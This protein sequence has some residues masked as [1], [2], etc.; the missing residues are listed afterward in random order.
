MSWGKDIV[1]NMGKIENKLNE[2]IKFLQYTYIENNS[3]KLIKLPKTLY[4]NWDK[5]LIKFF[6]MEFSLGIHKAVLH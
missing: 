5:I 6:F 3:E 2:L 4:K 1:K